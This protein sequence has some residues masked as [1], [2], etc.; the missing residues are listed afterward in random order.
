MGAGSVRGELEAAALEVDAALMQLPKARACGGGEA[1]TATEAGSAVLSSDE[2]HVSFRVDFP[3][4]TFAAQQVGDDEFQRMFMEGTGVSG[5]VGDPG[6]PIFS[7]FFA[8]LLGADVSVTVNDAK[9]Y[10]L[11]GVE[12]FP[13][14]TEPVDGKPSGVPALEQIDGL[15]PVSTFMPGPFQIDK[16][17]YD[18]KAKFPPTPSD[19]AVLGGIRDLR[20]GGVDFAGAQYTPKAE[21]LHVYTSIEVTV[22]FGGDNSG[23]FGDVDDIRSPW[24]AQFTRNYGALLE[25][26]DKSRQVPATGFRAVLLRRGDARRH[27]VDPADRGRHL[28][29]RPHSP[30]G[31]ATRVVEV[32]SGPG[33]IGTTREQIQSYILGR[34]NGRCL[35]RPSYVVIF[36]NTA[37]RAHLASALRPGRE[38]QRL[39]H[40]LRPTVSLN[41]PDP[42]RG[43][44]ARAH[45]G[46]G[47]GGRGRRRRQD[48][49]LR[50]DAAGAARG[51]TST[52]TPP[53]PGTSSRR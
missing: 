1:S 21:K 53:S 11:K 43:R 8:V 2:K 4:P 22:N 47:P 24:N 19:A 29:R 46:D 15:P 32:G 52:R 26:F 39:Q 27:V 30:P 50:D 48:P 9:G 49:H 14:Q 28:R 35:I 20:L 42:L 23:V 5:Y 40:R 45:P 6:P 18:S 44:H 31:F 41:G 51:T 12:L 16:K 13:V 37:A 10:D 38:P 3:Q 7:S 25:N 36:G 33:Q 17:A 34:L